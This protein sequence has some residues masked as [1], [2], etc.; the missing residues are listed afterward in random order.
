[1]KPTTTRALREHLSRDLKRAACGE[2]VVVTK[3]GRAYVRI[4]RAGAAEGQ[5]PKYPLRGS[6]LRVDDD[7][8]APLEHLFSALDA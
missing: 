1:M 3:R 5:A 7:F 2:E 4:V 8:D 6:V